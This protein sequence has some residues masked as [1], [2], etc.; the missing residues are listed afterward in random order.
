MN[1]TM[2]EFAIG[3]IAGTR[4]GRCIPTVVDRLARDGRASTPGDSHAATAGG[5]CSAT[6]GCIVTN[7]M[8]PAAA[9]ADVT[10]VALGV[11]TW[12]RL[13]DALLPAISAVLAITAA[14]VHLNA[15]LSG[16]HRHLP[17]QHEHHDCKDPRRP[18]TRPHPRR[19]RGNHY[20]PARR[21]HHQRARHR[22]RQSSG[23]R[24][25]RLAG[26]RRCA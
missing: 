4:I 1:G 12:R 3:T 22:R 5:Y 17:H 26:T 14:G 11:Q 19:H 24:Y 10:A 13:H 8:I 25:P 7:G 20:C 23:S 15:R 16:W 9:A 6:Y 2:V 21:R 18:P